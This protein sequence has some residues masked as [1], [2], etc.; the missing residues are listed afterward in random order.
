MSMHGHSIAKC[1]SGRLLCLEC[2]GT[3]KWGRL[4]ASEGPLHG[5]QESLGGPARAVAVRK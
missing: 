4:E 1:V 3:G 5:P 2:L